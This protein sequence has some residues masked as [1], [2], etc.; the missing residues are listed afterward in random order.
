M[1]NLRLK[2]YLF[3][4]RNYKA[5]GDLDIKF[6]KYLKKRKGFFI[7]IGANDGIHQ[8]NTF[9]L[10]KKKKWSGLLVE[11][12]M[13]AFASLIKNRSDQN[14]FI[15]AAC[16][17]FYYEKEFVEFNDYYLMGYIEDINT[18]NNTIE[19][20]KFSEEYIGKTDLKY[21]KYNVPAKTLNSILLENNA[22][23]NIDFFSLDVEGEELSVLEGLDF[24]IFKIKYIFIESRDK[25]RTIDFLVDKNYELIEDFNSNYLFRLKMS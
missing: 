25:K 18:D 7:E 20:K 17:P 3:R 21:S 4:R 13:K 10:E 2:I 24:S 19:H 11:P 6:K 23:K 5:Q 9:Y 14:I 12:G 8:S 15:N 16:V 22:P 1:K